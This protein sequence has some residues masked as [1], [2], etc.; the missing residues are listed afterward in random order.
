MPDARC[1]AVVEALTCACNPT[2]TYANRA[3]FRRHQLSQRH[4]EFEKRDAERHL[5][6]R[7]AEAE[8]DVARLRA[9]CARLRDLLA[10]PVKRRVTP[11]MKREV[12]ARAGWKCERCGEVVSANF[13]IDHKVPIFRGG[14]NSTANLQCLCPDCHRTK[15][16]D[17]RRASTPRPP[18]LLL[19]P[20]VGVPSA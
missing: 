11:R 18:D 6:V 1:A 12:A 3:S 15:T 8:A 5:R 13:E 9:E 20:V 16:E 7:L 14:D 19:A 17:D 4:I 10:H 2:K